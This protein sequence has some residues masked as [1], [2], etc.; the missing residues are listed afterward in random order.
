[1]PTQ[2]C[3]LICPM[4]VCSDIFH[5]SKAGT[6]RE[7]FD[8]FAFKALGQYCRL[9]I[10]MVVNACIED[11]VTQ[12]LSKNV[13]LFDPVVCLNNFNSFDNIK[14]NVFHILILIFRKFFLFIQLYLMFDTRLYLNLCLIFG[15]CECAVCVC[16]FVC[17][18]SNIAEKPRNS[19][20]RTVM[21]NWLRIFSWKKA[22]RL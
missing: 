4:H 2:V 13:S 6:I 9:H 10:I 7:V 12:K 1:M 15:Q 19:P 14:S 20:C 16:V 5:R 11:E 17:E 21:I 8:F 3:P 18:Y 22:E